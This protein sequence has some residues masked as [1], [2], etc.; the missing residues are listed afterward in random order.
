MIGLFS[1][2]AAV[3]VNVF[4]LLTFPLVGLAAYLVLRRLT[5]SRPVAIVCS[6][7]YT[8]LPYHFA[9]GEVHLLLSAYYVVPLGAYLVLAVLGD[10]PLF[11]DWRVDAR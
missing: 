9:R 3:V 11:G 6:I 7:L 1:S 5:L 2:D 8:L 10:R 4:F